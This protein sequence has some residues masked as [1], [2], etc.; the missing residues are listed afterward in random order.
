[1]DKTTTWAMMKGFG[2]GLVGAFVAGLA[3]SRLGFYDSQPVWVTV[4]TLVG[5][6]VGTA[7]GFGLT[8]R[9]DA[10]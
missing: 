7:I 5:A 2:G 10:T 3:L 1:M 8:E 9:A 4:V 6:A